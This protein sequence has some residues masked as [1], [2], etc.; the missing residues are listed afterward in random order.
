MGEGDQLTVKTISTFYTNSTTF[1]F[2]EQKE[3]K[4]ADGS[5]MMVTMSWDGDKLRGD[6]EPKEAGKGKRQYITRKIQ[7]DQLI[8]SMY[9]EDIV[10]K[11]IYKRKNPQT[12]SA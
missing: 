3:E 2:G 9:L 12:A 8:V 7:G 4:Q 1:T 5:V 10:A 6:Y 11:R